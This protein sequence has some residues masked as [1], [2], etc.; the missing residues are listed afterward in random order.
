MD[1]QIT[2]CTS[3]RKKA[4]D[5]FPGRE[6]LHRLKDMAASPG[7]EALKG[8]RLSEVAC[9]AG[10]GRP[11]T[12]SFQ[13][14]D[15]ATYLFG[16]IDPDV[17]LLDLVFF[18]KHYSASEDGWCSSADRPGKLGQTTLARI[19]APFRPLVDHHAVS[20]RVQAL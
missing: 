9:M 1:H 12:V 7:N 15:K 4:G 11:C 19:P 13:G 3:C 5:R 2:V 17:D 10:C 14:V 18:A 8:F 6:I 16:D 20:H